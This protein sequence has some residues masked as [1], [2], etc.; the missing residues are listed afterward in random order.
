MV[1][2]QEMREASIPPRTRPGEPSGR[3]CAETRGTCGANHSTLRKRVPVCHRKVTRWE[4]LP[5]AVETV[6]GGATTKCRCPGSPPWHRW[7]IP[8]GIAL[9]GRRTAVT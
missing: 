3:D 5:C 6:A 7:E 9:L 8:A 2:K 4:E 1:L